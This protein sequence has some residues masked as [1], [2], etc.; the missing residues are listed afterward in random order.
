MK[1]PLILTISLATAV[2]VVCVSIG[3][4]HI[5]KNANTR[6]EVS[7]VS[8]VS[9]PLWEDNSSYG[10]VTTDLTQDVY[11]TENQ[12]IQEVLVNEGDTVSVG[13]P[14][15]IMDNTLAML[16][17][18]MQAL[19]IDNIDLQIQAANRDIHFLETAAIG[20]AAPENAGGDELPEISKKADEHQLLS[21]PGTTPAD[22]D[23][24][25]YRLDR[26]TVLFLKD[27]TQNIYTVKCAP[28]TIITPD[29]LYR[30]K[31]LDMNTGRKIGEPLVVFLQIPS[32]G[33]RIYL[34]GYNFDIPEDFYEM[35][36][37][38]FMYNYNT[39]IS[40]ITSDGENEANPYDGITAEER[41]RQLTE[42]KNQLTTLNIDRKEAVLK[43]E[44]MRK[45]IADGTILST[46]NGQIKSVGDPNTGIDANAPFISVSSQ[47]GF[48]LKGTVN[49]LNVNSI[50]E[51]EPVIIRSRVDDSQTWKGTMG[52]IDKDSASS[53]NNNNSF[54]GMTDSS[55]SQT[56]TST[57]PFYVN[58]DSS[59]G[60]MLGQHVYIEMDE[61]QESQK[62]GIWLS[63]VYIVDADTDSPYVWAADKKGKL[64]KRSVILGQ[65][66]E[67][68]GEY[69]IA[70][71]LSKDDCIAYP[72]DILEEGMS[73]TTNIEDAMDTGNIDMQPLDDSSF[74]EDPLPDTAD[75]EGVSEYEMSDD[76]TVVDDPE[77]VD[78]SIVDD[79][80]SDESMDM[81]D[82]SSDSGEILDDN[83]MPVEEDTEEAQ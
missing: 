29:F 17:L 80:S 16:D 38:E 44:K 66:D 7:P 65:H 72:S 6:V 25:V 28:E 18:E 34:D 49:E 14:L 79:S 56:S 68:L 32:I 51:G 73:T 81:T 42:K 24:I 70:D 64:E 83:L 30:I 78:D 77:A 12:V 52:T 1:K 61:G 37:E 76:G 5:Y 33:K 26:Q 23:A 22:P 63:E 21:S 67:E 2:A 58:L 40:D 3:G 46:V 9:V 43:Y 27:D 47:D 15:M 74:S 53:G 69:E 71:G 60:L 62:T 54:Y 55:D 36:L 11:I 57:Y 35:T 31:G 4:Y 59:D 39:Q 75:T 41:D 10:V 8:A 48:Y 13:T 20:Y 19:A 50:V 82:G 45:E